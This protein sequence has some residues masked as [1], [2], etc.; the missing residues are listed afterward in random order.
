MYQINIFIYKSL[1]YELQD[2]RNLARVST[3]DSIDLGNNK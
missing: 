3:N 2:V 1:R